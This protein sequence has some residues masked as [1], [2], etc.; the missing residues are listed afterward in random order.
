MRAAVARPPPPAPTTMTLASCQHPLPMDLKST[1]YALSPPF[2]LLLQPTVSAFQVEYLAWIPYRYPCR[3]VSTRVPWGKPVVFSDAWW[4]GRK[5]E[6][7][8]EAELEFPKELNEGQP[9]EYDFKG[10]AGATSENKQGVNKTEV[11]Y[12]EE[13]SPKAEIEDDLS[14]G[15]N[16]LKDLMKATPVRHSERTAGK[17]FKFAEASSGDDS[18]ESDADISEGE[19]KKVGVELDSSMGNVTLE[20]ILIIFLFISSGVQI[21]LFISSVVQTIFFFQNLC[22]PAD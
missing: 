4:I 8:E 14:D 12:L 20:T 3:V 7:P 13:H 19:E 2:L 22:I 18:A 5:D 6:N 9:V 17:K 21:F 11:K 16:N 15:E 10:G 1:R